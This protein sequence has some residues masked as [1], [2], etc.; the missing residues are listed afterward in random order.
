MKYDVVSSE[1]MN[2][3]LGCTEGRLDDEATHF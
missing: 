2:N 3:K 1:F